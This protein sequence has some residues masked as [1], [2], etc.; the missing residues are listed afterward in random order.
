MRRSTYDFSAHLKCH[1]R[2]TQGCTNWKIMVTW[3]L[4]LNQPLWHSAKQARLPLWLVPCPVWKKGVM[5]IP[6]SFITT[7]LKSSTTTQHHHSNTLPLPPPIYALGNFVV[8]Y[9]GYSWKW[10]ELGV[11]SHRDPQFSIF[12]E[13]THT[14]NI[15]SNHFKSCFAVGIFSFPGRCELL[16]KYFE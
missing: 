14:H 6:M 15:Y 13:H 11:T 16:L 3:H 1:I 9:L 10:D 8:M 2:V 12:V 5:R 7:P 4:G